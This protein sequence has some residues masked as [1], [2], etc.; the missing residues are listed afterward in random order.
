MPAAALA[1]SDRE[2]TLDRLESERFDL[3][4]VGGGITGAGVAREAALRGLSVALLE[5][6]D[7]AAGT[8]EEEPLGWEA[9]RRAREEA[10]VR[11]RLAA[12]LAFQGRGE[13]EGPA[14]SEGARA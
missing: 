3:A 2:R 4:V 14:A 13:G 7:F 9:A 11:E 6:S 5:A 12:D 10:A 1:A 8:P